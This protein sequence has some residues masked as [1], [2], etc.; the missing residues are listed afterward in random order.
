VAEFW[1]PTAPCPRDEHE[2]L[3]VNQEKDAD[4]L[5][6]ISQDVRVEC[7][8]KYSLGNSSALVCRIRTAEDG[9]TESEYASIAS[10]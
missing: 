8:L 2:S 10:R 7:A 6:G 3:L 9:I 1:N 4:V 5:T